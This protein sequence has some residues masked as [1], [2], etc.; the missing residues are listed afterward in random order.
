MVLPHRFQPKISW[1]HCFVPGV[2]Q[3]IITAAAYKERAR[4]RERERGRER[5]REQMC[6][7]VGSGREDN[8]RER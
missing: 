6:G 7:G 1:I 5:E 2:A 4:E 3:T 8:M